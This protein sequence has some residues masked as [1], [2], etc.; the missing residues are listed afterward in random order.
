MT[1]FSQ[2]ITS[3][4]SGSIKTFKRF[5]AVMAM[6]VA[7]TF[8][9]FIKIESDRRGI[10]GNVLLLDSLQWALA[11]GA[12]SSLAAITYVR[13]RSKPKMQFTLANLLGLI[14]AAIAFILLY[15]FSI[16]ENPIVSGQSLTDISQS[17]I[18]IAIAISL[19]AF[20]SAAAYPKDQFDFSRS[21]FMAIKAFFV[22]LIYGL[23]IGG[24]TAAIAG[25]IEALLFPSM[26][27]TVYAYL[28]TLAGFLAFTIFV[29][30][31]PD[32]DPLEND[33]KKLTAGDQPRF[34]EILCE[35]ILIPIML[36]FTLVLLVWVIRILLPGDAPL[37]DILS[38]TIGSYAVAS[39]FLHILVTHYDSKLAR[40]YRQITPYALVVIL[41]FAFVSLSR[42]I[43]MDGLN[44]E[45]YWFILIALF[46][47]VSAV[48]LALKKQKAHVPMA[49]LA[50]ILLLVSVLPLVGVAELPV[51]SQIRRLESILE[52]EG[53]LTNGTLT[54]ATEEPSNEVRAKITNA[55]SFLAWSDID[56]LPPWFNREMRDPDVFRR[57]FG[58]SMQGYTETPGQDYIST[59]LMLPNLSL[60]ISDYEL[61][62]QLDGQGKGEPDNAVLTAE[63]VGTDG[64]YEFT[65]SARSSSIPDITLTLDGNEIYSNSLADYAD[66]ILE[67][68]P[69]SLENRWTPT[70]EDMTYRIDTGDQSILLV[71][72]TITINQA[73][74]D[75]TLSYWFDLMLIFISED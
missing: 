64:N 39:I 40:F 35:F 63:A 24:G 7:F 69:L 27:S 23:V 60:D 17:R 18:V 20:V 28:S 51:R 10:T 68:Y 3:V 74:G 4:F 25:A 57:S 21:L 65:W 12:T 70:T 11:L 73:P 66:Q 45:Y 52:D 37:V 56:D 29:G 41:A 5:P 6:A 47:L 46:S 9:I 54:P 19:I 75:D 8:I 1:K 43:R 48:L 55:V 22:A 13:T 33:P 15:F 44:T 67:Q 42:Q 32:F 62:L 26:S 30:Y 16:K 71:F 58:F 49:L 50:S 61:I 38:G 36:A 34:I 53:L 2:S 72:D 14:V 31:F 59:S